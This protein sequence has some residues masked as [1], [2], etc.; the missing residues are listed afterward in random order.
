MGRLGMYKVFQHEE[1][2]VGEMVVEF[3]Q[4]VVVVLFVVHCWKD[5]ATSQLG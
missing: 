3:T 2:D 1:L 4:V 5:A